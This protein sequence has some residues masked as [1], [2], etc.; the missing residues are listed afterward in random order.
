M[1]DAVRCTTRCSQK[2]HQK[3]SDYVRPCIHA[4]IPFGMVATTVLTESKLTP[5]EMQI[6]LFP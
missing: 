1:F 4:V 2:Q 3:E 5:L 6:F